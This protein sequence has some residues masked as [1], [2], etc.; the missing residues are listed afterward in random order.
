MVSTL[1]T[2]FQHLGL[3]IYS[4]TLGIE[5]WGQRRSRFE[6]CHGLSTSLFATCKFLMYSLQSPKWQ[7]HPKRVKI[8][9]ITCFVG[10]NCWK[11]RYWSTFSRYSIT[12]AYVTEATYWLPNFHCKIFCFFLLRGGLGG[13]KWEMFLEIK[14][15]TY[16]R[17][18]VYCEWFVINVF[19]NMEDTIVYGIPD[20]FV[21]CWC[22]DAM[23]FI[24]ANSEKIFLYIV[25]L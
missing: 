23:S 9:F 14:M 12:E 11:I 15:E 16:L 18:R 21:L 8:C 20:C 6:S 2:L 13:R 4:V 19:Q 10:R 5:N 3:T 1:K 7:L 17:F 25:N 24:W 22:N